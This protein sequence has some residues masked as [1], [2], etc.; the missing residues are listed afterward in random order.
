MLGKIKHAVE[1]AGWQVEFEEILLPHRAAA[2]FPGH[3]GETPRALQADRDMAAFGKC[4]QIPPRPTAEIQ[5][6]E[7]RLALDMPQ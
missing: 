6:R 4:F 1:M 2:E 7:R 3:R 5:Y